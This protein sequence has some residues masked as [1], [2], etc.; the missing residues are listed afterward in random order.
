MVK[1]TVVMSKKDAAQH[2]RLNG[3]YKLVREIDKNKAV[4]SIPSKDA[5]YLKRLGKAHTI[6]ETQTTVTKPQEQPAYSPSEEII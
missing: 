4:Y 1:A 5:I 3:D 6:K 2:N